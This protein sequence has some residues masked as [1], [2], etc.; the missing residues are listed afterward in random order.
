MMVHWPL[1]MSTDAARQRKQETSN[2]TC[3]KHC[4]PKHVALTGQSFSS[5][6]KGRLKS[7]NILEC[8]YSGCWESY[9]I[10]VYLVLIV[11]STTLLTIVNQNLVVPENKKLKFL[12]EETPEITFHHPYQISFNHWPTIPITEVAGNNPEIFSQ[13]P[14]WYCPHHHHSVPA[15]NTTVIIQLWQAPWSIIGK[16]LSHYGTTT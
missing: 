1:L 10:P 14:T 3:H 6:H 12:A 7:L 2:K 9:D 4:T 15:E 5:M 11:S 8:Q 13:L 16:W